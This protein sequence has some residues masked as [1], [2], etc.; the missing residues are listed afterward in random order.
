MVRLA[1]RLSVAQVPE[2][3]G[4]CAG[5]GPLELNL[6]DLVSAD[7]AGIEVLRRLRA[8]GATLVGMP[9]FLRL[10]LDSAP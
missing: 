6:T 2:L 3:L 1:G 4:A 9:Q 7:M 10:K 8:K 5:E